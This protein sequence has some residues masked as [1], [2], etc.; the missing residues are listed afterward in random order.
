MLKITWDAQ[1]RVNG[2]AWQNLGPILADLRVGTRCV[3]PGLS[4]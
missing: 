4:S 1:F 3:S 2:G